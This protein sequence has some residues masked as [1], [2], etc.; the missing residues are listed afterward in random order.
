MSTRVR[1]VV[2]ALMALA[3]AAAGACSPYTVRGRVVHGD[4]SYLMLVDRDDPRLLEPGIPGA[5]MKLTLDPGKLSRKTASQQ[6]SGADGDLALPVEE[7]GAGLLEFDAA[8]IVRKRGFA[9]AEGFFKLPGSGQ[10]VL[11]VL[12]PGRDEPSE[13][14]N[15]GSGEDLMKEAER[16]GR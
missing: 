16:F 10:R 11:V 15:S 5:Q 14:W 8:L 9:P 4:S 2:G 13:E 3:G 12:G 6:V 7:I 1:C